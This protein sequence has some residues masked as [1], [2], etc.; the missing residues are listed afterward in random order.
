MDIR[1]AAMISATIVLMGTSANAAPR[2]AQKGQGQPKE[3]IYC[4]QYENETGS[5]LARQQCMTR[6][7]WAQEGVNVD[8]LAKK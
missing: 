2:Q 4:I 3:Q 1:T 6:K 7:Q 5:R 8:E